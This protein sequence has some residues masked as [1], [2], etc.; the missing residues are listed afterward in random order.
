MRRR[1]CPFV[2]AN[3]LRLFY[4]N[5]QGHRLQTT[6]KQ[7]CRI[8]KTRA[9]EIGSRYYCQPEWLLYYL[10]DLCGRCDNPELDE[11]AG[12]VKAEVGQR[13]GRDKDIMAASLR[14]V[15]AQALGLDNSE[16]VQTLLA[17]Q[18][19]DGGWGLAW[20]VKYGSSS[21]K[22]GNRGVVTAMAVNAIRTSCAV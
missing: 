16:D 18:E 15:S 4:L 12:L 1:Y 19:L 14:A 17:T 10:A 5:G 21:L 13:I 2:A 11:L 20:M 8:L 6:L 7:L 9:Y 3:V 22:I